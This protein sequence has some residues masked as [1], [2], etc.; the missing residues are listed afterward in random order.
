MLVKLPQEKAGQNPIPIPPSINFRISIGLSLS[1]TTEGVKPASL[2]KLSQIC[3]NGF[4]PAK[5]IKF[6]PATSFKSIS[7]LNKK[8][9]E[10]GNGST[11]IG[12]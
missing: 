1:K 2:Q 4:E 6:S 10:R 7:G 12:F 5:A 9:E 8:R 3:L 11:K